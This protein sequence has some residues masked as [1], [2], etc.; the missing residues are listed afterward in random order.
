MHKTRAELRRSIC[1]R[2]SLVLAIGIALAGRCPRLL[3]VAGSMCKKNAT[4]AP[5]FFRLHA[6][7]ARNRLALGFTPMPAQQHIERARAPVL[8]PRRCDRKDLLPQSRLF[9]PSRHR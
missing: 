5:T 8:R 4:G 2:R 9:E 1:G 3:A 6:L 7:G